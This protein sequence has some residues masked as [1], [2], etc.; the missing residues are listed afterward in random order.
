VDR[1]AGFY[2][3]IFFAGATCSISIAPLPTCRLMR[4]DRQ[5]GPERIDGLV[6][7]EGGG[8]MV[9]RE[10]KEGESGDAG[11]RE[12]KRARARAREREREREREKEREDNEKSL[13]GS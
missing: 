3:R 2:R 10:A 9:T 5:S 1:V 12:G 7:G 4:R 13:K 8:G 11:S 6:F